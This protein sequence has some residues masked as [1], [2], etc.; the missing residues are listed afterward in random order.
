MMGGPVGCL[1][2]NRTTDKPTGARWKIVRVA[3]RA[4]ACA[5]VCVCIEGNALLIMAA[6]RV[7]AWLTVLP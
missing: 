7:Y 4:R 3:W 1:Q 6:A 2:A 5:R